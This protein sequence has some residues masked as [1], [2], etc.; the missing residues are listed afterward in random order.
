MLVLTT[1]GGGLVEVADRQQCLI[2]LNSGNVDS[3]SHISLA[4]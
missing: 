2:S 4:E 3:D 1:W